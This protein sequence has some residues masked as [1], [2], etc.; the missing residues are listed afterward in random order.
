MRI[1]YLF[2]FSKEELYQHFLKYFPYFIQRVPQYRTI[3]NKKTLN[4]PT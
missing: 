3:K 2:E 1:R 4:L